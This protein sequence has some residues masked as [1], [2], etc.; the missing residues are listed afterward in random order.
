MIHVDRARVPMPKVLSTDPRSPASL[1]RAAAEEFFRKRTGPR[2]SAKVSLQ[3]RFM[4]KVYRHSSVTEALNDLFLG[5]CAYCEVRYAA[6][7]PVEVEHFRPKSGVTESP[8]HPGYWWL[9]ATW[10][11]L[12]VSC[13]DCGRSRVMEDAKVG[14]ANRFPLENESHRAFK[15]GEETREAPLLLDP[16]TDNPA[17]HL[18]FDEAGVVT[19]STARGQMTIAVLGLNRKA[20]V[21]ERRRALAE[22]Q[23]WLGI[24]HTLIADLAVQRPAK[25]SPQMTVQLDALLDRLRAMTQ[26][27]EEF[28]AMKRQFIK[29]EL[30]ELEKRGLSEASQL[31]AGWEAPTPTITKQH[32]QQAQSAF[33]N[34]EREQSDYS[35]ADEKGRETYRS[36]RRQIERVTIRNFRG[37]EALD[38]ELGAGSGRTGWLMLLGE[39]AT[40]KS[41]VLQAIALTLAGA[42]YFARVASERGLA[43][44]QLVRDGAKQATIAVKMSGFVAPHELKLTPKQASF[45]KPSGDVATVKAVVA[46]GKPRVTKSRKRSSEA[47]SVVLG[48]GAT[49]LLP[50]RKSGRYGIEYARID[51]LFDP[52]LPL[53]DADKWLSTLTPPDFDSVAIV[54]KDLLALDEEAELLLEKG[55]VLVRMHDGKMPLRQLSDGYQAVIAMTVDVLEVAKRLWPHVT[56]AEGIVLLDE[57]GSHLHPLWKMRI[58]D[59]LRRAFPGMQFI[60]TTHE[61]L[62][63]RGLV[64]GEVVVMRR[65]AAKR[66]EAVTGLP[67]PSDFRVDQLLTS[68]FFGL[69][70]TVDAGVEKVFDEYY[71]LL[72]LGSRTPEQQSRLAELRESLKDRRYLGNTLREQLMYEAIDQLVARHKRGE[73]KP[74]PQLKREAVAEIERI[75]NEP[76]PSRRTRS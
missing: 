30:D 76:L 54:L 61:P 23:N 45:R 58:V 56:E 12:L 75:W 31:A 33:Q 29:P 36:Q 51:N 41:S 19:S 21:E 9:A 71:A 74:I 67:S 37:I 8:K 27:S 6:R 13:I 50:R 49:R 11:N 15:P 39:N 59:S 62:C 4:F 2:K 24:A 70:S 34:F 28:A 42:D 26:A 73:R 7:M 72:A 52:F 44:G 1:E 32:R 68:E 14:K 66:I 47:Q 22:V 60:A 20:L 16:C 3:Q 10:T 69:N 18:V 5:K 17:E 57:I 64:E 25:P 65:D 63:L 55:R 43:F 40:G 53:F 48:Y 35:L 38:L 46:G